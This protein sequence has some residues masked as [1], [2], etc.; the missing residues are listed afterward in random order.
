MKL[1]ERVY[2]PLWLVVIRGF[3]QE[4]II[5]LT[6]IA[7]TKDREHAVWIAD[8]CLMQWKCEEAY[9]FVKQAYGLEDV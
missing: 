3:G 6:N 4:P 8:I 1:P 2:T 5:L 9:R 7:P